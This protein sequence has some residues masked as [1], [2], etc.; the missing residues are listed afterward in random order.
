MKLD[1]RLN[2]GIELH[3]GTRI[4]NGSEVSSE[5]LHT[6]LL[7]ITAG[8]HSINEFNDTVYFYKKGEF[9]DISTHEEMDHKGTSYTFYFLRESQGFVTDLWGVKDNG[10]YV[11]DGFLIAYQKDIEE[12]TTFKASLSE[13]FSAASAERG[14]FEF[15]R[16]EVETALQ[17]F[18]PFSIDDISEE[19]MG[20]KFPNFE[21]FYKNKGPERMHKA[22]YFTLGARNNAAL[23]MKIVLYCT[24]L[25]CLF[26][27]AK[28]EINHRIA[29]RIATMLGTSAEEKKDLFK[30]IKKAYDY[31]STIIHGANLKGDE[32]AIV[33]ISV[34]LDEILRQ[35]LAGDHEVFTKSDGEIDN[36]FVDL[37]FN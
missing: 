7:Q 27:T 11:R 5:I 33:K 32:E 25:E 2:R 19:D 37:I 9:L 1:S 16:K 20:M 36:F 30:F 28:T 31:R 6:K 14:E 13:V 26:S 18:N 21:H 12:G 8:V 15:T 34:R 29:E 23:P 17:T 35:L 3:P 4:S 22:H 10:I 24:A